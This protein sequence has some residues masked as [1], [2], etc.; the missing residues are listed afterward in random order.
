MAGWYHYGRRGLGGSYNASSAELGDASLMEA[1]G[2]MLEQDLLLQNQRLQ[3]HHPYPIL[4]TSSRNRSC[5]E[6][7][8][9][10]SAHH[11]RT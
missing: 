6:P 10:I 1:K 2:F 9:A 11:A 5:S 8:F 7:A 4:T 3:V